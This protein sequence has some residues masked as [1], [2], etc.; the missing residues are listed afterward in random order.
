MNSGAEGAKNVFRG[1][2]GV[3]HNF[4]AVEN[5]LN[6]FSLST[7]HMMLSLDHLVVL[8]PPIPFS[9]VL[10]PGPPAAP[11]WFGFRVLHFVSRKS[12]T[13][14]WGGRG[15]LPP[16]LISGANQMAVEAVG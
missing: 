6:K 7:G 9:F 1:A 16:P 10:G 5:G 15:H 8:I 14:G 2:K 11:C 3:I 12:S 4:L 13:D